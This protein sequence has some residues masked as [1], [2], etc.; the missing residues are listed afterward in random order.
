MIP[1]NE[2]DDMNVD[3]DGNPVVTPGT[4]EDFDPEKLFKEYSADPAYTG[5][6]KKETCWDEVVAA[7]KKCKEKQQAA[8]EKCKDLRYK[9]QC[10]L[11]DAGCPSVVRATKKGKSKCG[12][13]SGGCAG[14]ACALPRL[15]A[16]AGTS[17]AKSACAKLK[18]KYSKPGTRACTRYSKSKL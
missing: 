2:G 5:C 16:T 8:S 11:K 6:D 7:K 4:T 9:V 13:T 12:L 14:G 3:G 10:M 18:A 15:T 17:T 1:I